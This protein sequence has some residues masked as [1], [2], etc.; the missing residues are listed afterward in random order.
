M[1]QI[2]YST[3]LPLLPPAERRLLGLEAGGLWGMTW[4]AMCVRVPLA[5]Q[6]KK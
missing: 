4:R 3:T 2:T 5:T 6:G 1:S